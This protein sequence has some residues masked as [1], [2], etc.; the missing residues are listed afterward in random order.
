LHKTLVYKSASEGWPVQKYTFLKFPWHIYICTKLS[1]KAEDV[2]KQT[3]RWHIEGIFLQPHAAS[4][5]AALLN[6]PIHWYYTLCVS[7]C[8]SRKIRVWR[9]SSN[10]D[11][12]S[13]RKF[14]T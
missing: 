5:V 9:N 13:D 8:M 6:T 1:F 12:F 4:V 3:N 7:C 2:W 10:L 11:H 14:D